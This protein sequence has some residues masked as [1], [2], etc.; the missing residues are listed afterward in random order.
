MKKHFNEKLMDII[1]KKRDR[2]ID[3]EIIKNGLKENKELRRKFETRIDEIQSYI[4]A[5]I[6]YYR[7]INDNHKYNHIRNKLWEKKKNLKNGIE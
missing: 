5:N 1:R 7:D 3:S 6:Y 4:A 2:D